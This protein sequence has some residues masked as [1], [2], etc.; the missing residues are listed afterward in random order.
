MARPQQGDMIVWTEP[1]S[2]RRERMGWFI[3]EI[4]SVIVDDGAVVETGTN[5][6]WVVSTSDTCE[7]EVVLPAQV[8]STASLAPGEYWPSE[9]C[10]PIA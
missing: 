7:T 1:T 8:T 10:R 2:G 4:R 9:S 3:R 6:V 5:A